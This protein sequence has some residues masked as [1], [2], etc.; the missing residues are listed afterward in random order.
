VTEDRGDWL[1]VLLPVRPNGST[2]WVRE[3]D[4]N[5]KKHGYRIVVALGAHTFTAYAYDK[6]FLSGEVAIGTVDTPTPVGLY[7][8]TELLQQPD[9]NGTYGPYAYGLSG[10]SD[11]LTDFAGGA[12]ELGLHGTNEPASLGHDVSHGC[13]RMTND[14]ITQLARTLPLGTPVQ[15][16]G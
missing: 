16:V 10:Y 3:I 7:S 9:P 11:V 6:V 14:D 5:L 8:T 2:G 15:V 1:K 12:G 4:V 13:I